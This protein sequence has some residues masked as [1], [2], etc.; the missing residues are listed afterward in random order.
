MN[1]LKD[2]G[3]TK[4]WVTADIKDEAQ[5]IKEKYCYVADDLIKEYRKFDEPIVLDNE[6]GTKKYALSKK[7]KKHHY[8]PSNGQKPIEIDIAYE[9]FLG[10]EIFFH[11]VSINNYI[12][13]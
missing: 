12:I 13:Y 1:R 10:P 5:R 9:R 7:F 6:D 11:P 3:E 2:R 8:K 4:G